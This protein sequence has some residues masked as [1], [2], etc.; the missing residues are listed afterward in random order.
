MGA[1]TR[2]CPG[3]RGAASLWAS[4]EPRPARQP[5][6]RREGGAGLRV[7]VRRPGRVQAWRR[8]SRPVSLALTPVT[9]ALP[10][11]CP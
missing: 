1:W 9:P 7:S 8:P 6:D 3:Q 4:Q 5:V 10:A 2:G 11:P